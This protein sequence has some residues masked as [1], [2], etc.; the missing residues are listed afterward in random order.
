MRGRLVWSDGERREPPKVR[1]K[2]LGEGG[3]IQQEATEKTEKSSDSVSSVPSCSKNA[4]L[5]E[6]SV[7]TSPS[8]VAHPVIT[9]DP[10]AVPL[11]T[12][13][14]AA[15]TLLFQIERHWRGIGESRRWA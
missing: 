5:V 15:M 9:P 11:P 2:G 10:L 8:C 14:N 4:F 7:W 3:A 12:A 13:P 1:E 6:E